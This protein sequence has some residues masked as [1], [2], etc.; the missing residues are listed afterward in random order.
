MTVSYLW[1]KLCKKITGSAVKDCKI[2][3]TSKIEAGCN[4]VNSTFGRYSFCGYGCTIVN[5][6]VGAFCSISNDVVI[7]GARHPM[8]WVS[9]SPAFS[10]RRDSI[11][12]KFAKHDKGDTLRTLVG[13]DV[14]IGERALIK[15]GVRIGDGAVVGMGSVVTKDV[16]PYSVAAG[17][18][19]RTIRMRFDDYIIAKLSMIK[20]WEFDEE[21]LHKYAKYVPSPEVFIR[22]VEGE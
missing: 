17:C 20:W 6:D 2:D 8:E 1:A 21:L 18:P 19:A 12:K 22:E 5:C 11:K 3:R 16:R 15:A 10:S 7:G 14:W 4:V 13:N 9:M